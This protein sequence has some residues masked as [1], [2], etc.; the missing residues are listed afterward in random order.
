MDQYLKSACKKPVYF[1][2]IMLDLRVIG[3]YFKQV[4]MSQLKNF[5]VE[6]SRRF[7]APVTADRMNDASVVAKSFTAQMATICKRRRV[8][9][10]KN[11]VNEYFKSPLEPFEIDSI[12]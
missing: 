5:W 9:T 6:I 7:D 2:A 4:D 11:E 1:C 12:L 3:D 8:T 10:L